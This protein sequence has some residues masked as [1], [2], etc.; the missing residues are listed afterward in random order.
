[1]KILVSGCAGFIGSHVCLKLLKNTNDIII[2]IDNINEYYNKEQKEYNL[3][4]LQ[5]YDN[6]IFVKEDI[7]STKIIEKYKP[8]K[9]CHLA[10]CAGVRYSIENPCLYSR[11]NIEGFINLLEQACKTNVKTFVYASSSSVYGLEKEIPFHEKVKIDK[12]NSPY[13]VT[14]RC[15]E[16][17][18]DMFH[19]LYS[20][21]SIIGL[22]FFTVYGPQGRPDMAPY[23]F[24]NSIINNEEITQYGDG[25]SKRDYTYID[26]IVDGIISALENKKEIKCEVINLGNS[27]PITLKQ[28]I[29]T[30][31]KISNKKAKIKII[32]NQKGDVPITFANIEKAQR[33]LDYNPKTDIEIGL[34]KTFE[35]MNYN[36]KNK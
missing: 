35:W 20:D 14:K 23:K 17:F 34:T 3:K 5:K 8:E 27:N 30:C 9:V 21:I 7:V 6:F 33:L 4:N 29:N 11:V 16:L 2:G 32:E 36:K 18:A 19:R 12:C 28:F 24:L 22:R 15:K 31:E 13:A 26:D 1:M 10:A 25:N